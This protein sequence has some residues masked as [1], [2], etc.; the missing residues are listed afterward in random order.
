[1]STFKTTLEI[2]AVLNLILCIFCA[3]MRFTGF[4]TKTSDYPGMT[5]TPPSE[6]RW[7]DLTETEKNQKVAT[8]LAVGT[9]FPW[10]FAG[11]CWAVYFFY[12]FYLW[13]IGAIAHLLHLTS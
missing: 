2:I 11:G 5:G 9:V 8:V 3:L 10:L 13:A 6:K 12:G 7:K 1:V 4:G